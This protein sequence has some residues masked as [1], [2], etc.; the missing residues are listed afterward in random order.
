M[1]LYQVEHDNCEPYEDNF[2]FREDKVYTDKDNLIK[3]I[4]DHGYKEE[5]N[6]LGEQEFIK[7]ALGEYE[8]ERDLVT[9]HELEVIDNRE[10]V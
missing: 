2:H 3:R 10:D 5:T 6:Y 1:K 7:E 8:L 9:I 4:K